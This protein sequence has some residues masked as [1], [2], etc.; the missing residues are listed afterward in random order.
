MAMRPGVKTIS[1]KTYDV[2]PTTTQES[3]MCML[4]EHEKGTMKKMAEQ[5]RKH[6][7]KLEAIKQT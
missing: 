3:I 7:Y 1:T 4:A 2:T 6:E 5:T